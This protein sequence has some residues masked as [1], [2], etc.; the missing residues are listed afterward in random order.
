MTNDDQQDVVQWEDESDEPPCP[1]GDRFLEVKHAVASG[2]DGYQHLDT[3]DRKKCLMDIERKARLICESF[4]IDIHIDLS[5]S[6]EESQL[7]GHIEH[8]VKCRQL[9]DIIRREL[10]ALD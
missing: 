9:L 2:T 10:A 7:D 3:A 6:G 5:Q 4:E 8:Y 1:F